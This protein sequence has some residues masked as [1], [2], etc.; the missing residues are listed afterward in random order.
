MAWEEWELIDRFVYPHKH[1]LCIKTSITSLSAS[2]LVVKSIVAIDGPRVRFAAGAILF[3]FFFFVLIEK[4][5]MPRSKYGIS[6]AYIIHPLGIP[7]IPFISSACYIHQTSIVTPGRF[8]RP[9]RQ[10]QLS[11]YGSRIM[12]KRH[13]PILDTPMDTS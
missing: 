8:N 11:P 1:S 5:H 4:L 12:L 7:C 2:G 13:P 3:L 6:Q 9:A 10:P